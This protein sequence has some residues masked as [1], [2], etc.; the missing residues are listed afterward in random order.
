MFDTP[1]VDVE[2]KFQV[3]VV[4]TVE[5]VKDVVRRSLVETRQGTHEGKHGRFNIVQFV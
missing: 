2:V 5:K 1:A 3:K 4:L